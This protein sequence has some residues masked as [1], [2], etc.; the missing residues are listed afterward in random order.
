MPELQQKVVGHFDIPEEIAKELSEL[1]TKQM[2]REKLLRQIIT[3]D[4]SKYEEA[5]K[6]L[7]PVA[8]KV[9][10]IKMRITNEFV[11]EQYRNPIYIWNYN[12]YEVDGCSVEVIQMIEVDL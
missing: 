7:I 10:A 9:E 12:G 5:E 8:A 1:L 3:E 11:P 4:P 2:I 6:V